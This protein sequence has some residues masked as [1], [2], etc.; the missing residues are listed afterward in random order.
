MLPFDETS[1]GHLARARKRLEGDDRADLFYAAL[2]LRF[3]VEARQNDYVQA[4]SRYLKSIP[5]AHKIGN[6]AAALRRLFDRDETLRVEIDFHDLPPK[7]L[8]YTPVTNELKKSA[9]KLGD[10]LHIQKV[11]RSGD[12]AWWL[13]QK[14]FLLQTY[15]SAWYACRGEMLSPLLL[16]RDKSVV[17]AIELVADQ[18]PL[19][20]E[21]IG[22]VGR[23]AIFNVSYIDKLPA[24]LSPDI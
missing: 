11:R 19:F 10:L 16:L 12:E 24:D 23:T 9:E 6:Q 21:R 17:G 20:F 4:Q 14:S 1:R 13:S 15:R 7:V 5:A 18:D 22:E 8:Y 2:E 3:C